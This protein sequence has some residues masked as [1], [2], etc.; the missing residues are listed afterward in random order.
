MTSRRQSRGIAARAPVALPPCG[1][2]A[3]A[4]P[5][6]LSLHVP[7]PRP[8]L[9]LV[10]PAASIRAVLT[11]PAASNGLL[12]ATTKRVGAGD[13]TRALARA[14]VRPLTHV[15][16]VLLVHVHDLGPQRCESPAHTLQTHRQRARSRSLNVYVEVQAH[17][18]R[19]SGIGASD[20]H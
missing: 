9:S 16:H 7:L 11:L 5:S 19:V 15:V 8:L 2:R 18:R 14:R 17:D 3:A 13:D 4:A 10:Q 20:A 1:A 12:R 6:Q